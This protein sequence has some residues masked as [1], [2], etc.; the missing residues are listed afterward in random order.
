[1][2][3]LGSSIYILPQKYLTFNKNLTQITYCDKKLIIAMLKLRKVIE[4]KMK[5]IKQGAKLSS[6]VGSGGLLLKITG[7]IDH[8]NAKLI[9]KQ[10]DDDIFLHRPKKTVLDLSGVDFMDSS[11]LGLIL[12]R[13]NSAEEVGGTLVLR[14]PSKRVE[15]VLTLAGIDKMITVE[16]TEKEN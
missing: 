5:M 9:R 7:E 13:F 14:S 8:H 11:G 15:K 16:K 3:L 1:M 6:S 2:Y 10:M 4:R 12:G